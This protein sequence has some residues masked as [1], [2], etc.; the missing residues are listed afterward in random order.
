MCTQVVCCLE[1]D[2]N[3]EALRLCQEQLAG[4]RGRLLPHTAASLMSLQVQA[5]LQAGNCEKAALVAGDAIRLADRAGLARLMPTLKRQQQE[6]TH[7]L[8]EPL[9]A[10]QLPESPSAAVA[11]LYEA[12]WQLFNA[13]RT[14]PTSLNWSTDADAYLQRAEEQ[15]VHMPPQSAAVWAANIAFLRACVM[16]VHQ[17]PTATV[18]HH[19]RQAVRCIASHSTVCLCTTHMHVDRGRHVMGLSSEG[20]CKMLAS[21]LLAQSGMR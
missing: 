10:E 14:L 21:A 5:C 7:I 15:L 2:G 16:A 13:R 20:A 18:I 19:L 8:L 3:A 17:G 11:C 6:A 12:A 1:Q 4:W 9:A